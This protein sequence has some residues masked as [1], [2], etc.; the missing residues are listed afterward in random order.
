[1]VP[2]LRTI[3]S[4]VEGGHGGDG[5]GPKVVFD[6]SGLTQ[7]IAKTDRG[8]QK[9]GGD[10]E[11]ADGPEA[12]EA[13]IAE[14]AGEDDNAED[15]RGAEAAEEEEPESDSPIGS[16]WNY[17]VQGDPQGPHMWTV[18]PPR[19]IRPP[20]GATT[21][22]WDYIEDT[23]RLIRHHVV[24]RYSTFGNRPQD[25]DGCPVRP[26]HIN[27]IRRTTMHMEPGSQVLVDDWREWYGQ[28]MQIQQH[29]WTGHT[30]FIRL[31]AGDSEEL[32]EVAGGGEEPEEDS[33]PGTP[34]EEAGESEEAVE[35]DIHEVSAHAPPSDDRRSSTRSR[36]R[37]RGVQGPDHE[38]NGRR[39]GYADDTSRLESL[40][41]ML[42]DESMA[43]K[44]ASDYVEWCTEDV[45]YDRMRVKEAVCRGDRLLHAA[46]ALR[47]RCGHY[48]RRATESSANP[49]EER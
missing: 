37:S 49:C 7:K 36:A 30:E 38:E 27:G 19:S 40:G 35:E 14:D 20:N 17:S 6:T 22:V 11:D 29:P 21:D 5:T 13:E 1:M 25:W 4:K 8:T 2:K 43:E 12:G 33:E 47:R 3:L 10:A 31:N 15:A 46:G 41:A 23:G 24:P 28:G 32:E 44:A 9:C 18:W 16:S 48:G 34:Q 26:A 42:N 45:A 39:V